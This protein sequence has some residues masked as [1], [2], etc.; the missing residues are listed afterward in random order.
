[1]KILSIFIKSITDTLSWNIVKLALV[2]TVSLGVIWFGIGTLFWNKMINITSYFISWIPFSILKA[3]AAF[4]IGGFSWFL[5]V[6]STYAIIMALLNIPISKIVSPKRYEFFTIVLIVFI[7]I[8]WTIFAMFHWDFVYKE[9]EKVLTWFPFQ[10]LEDGVSALLA[11]L[12]F[13]NFYIVSIY[14]VVMFFNKPFL[15]I[16]AIENFSDISLKNSI[17]SS[18]FL[19]IIFKDL[20]IFLLFLLFAFPLFFV[21][22][23]NIFIQVFL[24][25]WLIKESY[26]LSA[27]SLY[28]TKEQLDKLNKYS[29]QKWALAFIASL[30]NLVPIANLF[31]PFFA[32]IL[33][34]HWIMQNK[35]R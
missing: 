15:E 14:F 16:V 9:L 29:L 13:Y 6:L 19:K 32:Q 8:S 10:T 3:N 17:K 26:F 30:L 25:A 18:K 2:I 27:G 31:A 23:V 21:P 34:F 22:F 7:S 4:L 12:V 11:I 24:W 35:D 20:S 33:F 1:M 28:A 5:I